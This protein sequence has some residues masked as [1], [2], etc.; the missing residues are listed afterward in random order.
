MHENEHILWEKILKWKCDDLQQK[1]YKQKFNNET[2]FTS[3][4]KFDSCITSDNFINV[5][6]LFFKI[7]VTYKNI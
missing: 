4:S 3:H 7:C 2:D 1:K 5:C 6:Y